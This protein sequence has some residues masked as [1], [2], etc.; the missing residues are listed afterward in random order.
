M[1][2]IEVDRVTVEQGPWLEVN[3]D[4]LQR[5]AR[6]YARRV[7]V[8][9]LPMVKANGYGLGAAT[10]ARA[11]EPLG[12]WGFGVAT[13]AEAAQLRAA[14]IE[15]PIVV[16]LPYQS[17]ALER[18]LAL[19]ARPAIG[20]L[21]EL[22]LWRGWGDRP[23]HLAIDT[24]MARGGIPWHD[25]DLLTAIGPRLGAGFEGAFTHFHS[26]DI[27]ETATAQ[28]WDRF[29]EALGALG[30]RPP[31]VHAANS[32]AG[33]WGSRYAGTMARPGIFLY[34]GSAGPLRPEPVA[35]FE[36]R[37][38]A[39]TP[40]RAGDTVSYGASYRTPVAGEV[41]TLAA[42]Y[43][44]GV[45]RSLSNAG[46]VGLGDRLVP[47]AGRVTMDMTMVV[48]PRGTVRVGDRAT[49]FGGS[50]G[51]DAQAARAGTISYELL[52]SVGPRVIRRYHGG[53]S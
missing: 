51:L 38:Q 42:G 20:G 1:A 24:G 17:D 19:D 2:A 47:I 48:V 50:N 4:A 23:F 49:F 16:F 33:R 18:H 40:I 46:L 41:A 5:N 7:G 8:P 13:V 10:V 37:V 11:L 27:D 30:R 34:G 9:V 15:R 29:E 22:E 35:R 28:Q 43:A 26:A 53:S 44:D 21:E 6:E 39:V 31:I 3:L 32:A 36:A 45:L 25:R 52:T 14:G 12:P